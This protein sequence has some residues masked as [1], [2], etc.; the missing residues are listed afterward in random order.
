[1]LYQI[2]RYLHLIHADIADPYQ[3]P[4][5]TITVIVEQTNTPGM[6]D[7]Q[8]KRKFLAV[9]MLPELFERAKVEAANRDIPVT[10]FVRACVVK[11]LCR[12]ESIPNE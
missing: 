3:C 5:D 9:T 11:E 7:S 10:A 6:T 2:W 4:V 8:A 12:T 1:M